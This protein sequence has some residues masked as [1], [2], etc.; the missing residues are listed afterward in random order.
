M[1]VISLAQ[2]RTASTQQNIGTSDTWDTA[3]AYGCMEFRRGNMDK[4]RELFQNGVWADPSSKGVTAV[5]QVSP[6]NCCSAA[7]VE[8]HVSV[9][10]ASKHLLILPTTATE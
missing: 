1:P 6:A 7:E 9:A 4:A 5:W 3:Q 2:L 8:T 10:A